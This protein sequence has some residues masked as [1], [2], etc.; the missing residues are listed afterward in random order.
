M[1]TSDLPAQLLAA[2]GRSTPSSVS[3]G[4]GGMATVFLAHD[5]K[6]HRP[7]AIKVLHPDLAASLGPERFR[8]EIALAAQ[9]QHPHIL[10]VFDSGETPA[11][12]VVHH[13]VC[14][15]RESCA[16]GC[17]GR[18][19]LGVDDAL[20]IAREVAGALDYAHQHGVIHRDIKPENVLLTQ[21]GDALLADFGIARALTSDPD[22][23]ESGWH[24][25]HG[26]WTHRRHA[27]VHE[28][29]AGL[30]RARSHRSERY[31]LARRRALRDARRRAAIH[32][33]DAASR[34]REDALERAALGP[35]CA[36]TV[37]ATTSMPRC[38]KRCRRCRPTGGP[39]RETLRAALAAGRA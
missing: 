8:R 11:A 30:G 14:R 27:A 16:T 35:S 3:W 33:T 32:R 36:P 2:L 13:A 9:L 1:A 37:S 24:R 18:K 12:A 15:G 6:H 28:P 22:K 25:A 20:R 7:V 4:R 29:R 17:I 26:Y 38:R 31:L 34:H 39:A 19:Q 10:S 21:Q 5:N 23:S